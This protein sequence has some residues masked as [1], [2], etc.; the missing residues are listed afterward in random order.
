MVKLV[1]INL[2]EKYYDTVQNSSLP[3]LFL[4]SYLCLL[5]YL[6]QNIKRQILMTWVFTVYL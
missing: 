1:Q 4:F 5:N 3:I 6:Q 2:S